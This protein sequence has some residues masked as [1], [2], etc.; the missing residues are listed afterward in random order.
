MA[1]KGL[2]LSS[3]LRLIVS[4]GPELTLMFLGVAI[5]STRHPQLNIMVLCEL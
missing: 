2:V 3:I 1:I 4:A 5:V